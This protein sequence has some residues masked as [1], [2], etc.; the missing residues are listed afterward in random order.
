MSEIMESS[1]VIGE[2]SVKFLY[3]SCMDSTH[4]HKSQDVAEK[5][6]KKSIKKLTYIE[7]TLIT[8]QDALYVKKLMDE[9]LSRK[10]IAEIIGLSTASVDSRISKYWRFVRMGAYK[11][12]IKE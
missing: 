10:K 11:T 5:C 1:L 2:K 8:K 7:P 4:Q 6:I 9:G 12:D 3:W